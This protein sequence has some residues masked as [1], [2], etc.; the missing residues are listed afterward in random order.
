MIR[1]SSLEDNIKKKIAF[2]DLF[3]EI[4]EQS[5]AIT[6]LHSKVILK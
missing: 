1:C 3:I 6:A 5:N 4:F 2:Q